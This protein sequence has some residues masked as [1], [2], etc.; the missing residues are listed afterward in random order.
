ME[1]YP[2]WRYHRTEKPRLVRNS[3]EDA[4]LEDGWE[5]TPAKFLLQEVTEEVGGVPPDENESEDEPT[6]EHRSTP[7]KELKK[8][9]Q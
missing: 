8:R 3:A 2:S 7:K 5:D 9:R 4:A 1:Y 6:R